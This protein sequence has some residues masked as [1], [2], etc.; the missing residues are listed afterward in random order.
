[1]EDF[2]AKIQMFFFNVGSRKNHFVYEAIGNKI[3]DI[4]TS[5][6]IK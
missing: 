6:T 1:M 4:R 3:Q 5:L 2:L